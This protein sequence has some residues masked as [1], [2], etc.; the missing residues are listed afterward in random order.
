MKALYKKI[1]PYI[2]SLEILFMSF[3]SCSITVRASDFVARDII[4]SVEYGIEF[5]DWNPFWDFLYSSGD[6]LVYMLS[7]MGAFVTKDFVKWVNNDRALESLVETVPVPAKKEDNNIVFTKE[8]MTQLK[9]LL[10][11]YA[12]ENQPFYL[13]NTTRASSVPST[14]FRSKQMY[15][16]FR[17]YVSSHNLTSFIC[18]K[19]GILFSDV[20]PVIK[21]GGGF[22]VFYAGID[23]IL[24]GRA[25]L[26]MYD[27]N[28]QKYSP[29][30]DLYSFDETGDFIGVSENFKSFSRLYVYHSCDYSHSSLDPVVV[31]QD[32]GRIRVFKSKT[33][34]IS[35]S[36]GQ[37]KIYYTSNYYDYV[38][39]DLQVSI[40]DLQKTIDDMQDVIDKLLDQIT[41]DTSE[42]EIEELL[43]LILEE[44]KN[45]QGGGGDGSGGGNTG[46][47]DVNVDI[48]LSGTNSLLSK[49]LA[50]VTQISEKISTSAGQSMTDVVNSIKELGEML[51]KY[52]KTITGDLD[53]IKNKLD[54]MTEEQFSEKADS[55]LNETAGSFSEIGEV[56]K[57]K[58]PFSIPND[59]RTLLELLSIPPPSPETSALYDA[60]SPAILPL[61]GDHGGGGSSRPPTVGIASVEQG[62]GGGSFGISESGAPV[63]LCPIVIKR[64]GIDYAI[65]ID[66]SDF[67][68]VAALARTFLTFLFI[69]GLYNLT[70]KVMGLWGDL[71]E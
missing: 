42:S 55:F 44:L 50:K 3:F 47:G 69:Y 57:G 5:N 52:L 41:N 18:E 17:N 36:A 16:T 43:R 27:G 23:P 33:D 29:M 24:N 49:I 66:L 67:D 30:F 1:L 28:W 53:D 22:V 63:I 46:G 64:L 71:T 48:D 68:K 20:A 65:K 26:S 15:N 19:D 25:Y 39:E 12:A 54:E 61:S 4:E 7:Q 11:D 56:A 21:D 37:R 60:G 34:L 35:Y 40:D 70:F 9:Q 13:C 32:G 51:K 45:N 2:L 59:M 62:S 38:P 10:D 14:V 58:F 8:F 31:T 6:G